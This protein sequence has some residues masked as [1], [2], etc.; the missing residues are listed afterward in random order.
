MNADSIAAIESFTPNSKPYG[1][2]FGEWT[3]RWWQWAHGSPK[4]LNPVLDQTGVNANI[5]Q[6]GPVWFLAG[7]FGE[8]NIAKRSCTLPFGK[9]IL[10]PVINYEMN[11]LENPRIRTGRDLVKHVLQD[12][13]DIV[14]KQAIVDGKEV[15]IYRIQSDPSIFE[16]N[17]DSDN[18]MGIRG[19]ITKAA[20]DGYWVFLKPLD[21]GQHTIYFHGACS[22]GTRNAAAE[23]CI[24][25]HHT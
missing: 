19:G 10:F 18:C 5:N 1:L 8:N 3:V 4:A 20:A 11:E 14:V 7:T 16:L 17:I 9:A 23:Y 22:G 13:D 2:T 12:I 25:V 15:P 21:L 6:S 24:D